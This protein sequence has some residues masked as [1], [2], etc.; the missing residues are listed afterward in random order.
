MTTARRSILAYASAFLGL[1]AVVGVLCFHF[2]QLLTSKDF[3]AV[4]TEDFARHLL[5]AGLIAAFTT[6]TVAILRGRNRRVAMLGV[7]SATLA[8]VLGGTNVQFDAIGQT[9]YSLGLDWF[10]ISLFF[11]ALVFVPLENARCSAE[12]AAAPGVAHR[13]GLLLH[14]PRAGAVHPDRGDRI[15]QARSPRW[16]RSRR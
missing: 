5:L 2:P 4:Y 8:V 15:H 12:V 3:R 10:V 9:P 6:G 11:S 1:S 7:G 13:P 14:E 16:P